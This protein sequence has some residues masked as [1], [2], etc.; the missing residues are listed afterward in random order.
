[1]DADSS[2]SRSRTAESTTGPPADFSTHLRIVGRV[3]VTEYQRK[4]QLFP[5]KLASSF[6]ICDKK[7][8]LGID[9]RRFAWR[10]FSLARR[11]G[12]SRFHSAPTTEAVLSCDHFLCIAQFEV[13]QKNLR[14]GHIRKTRHK[15]P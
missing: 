2:P 11:G 13:R 7:L 12:Q 3:A 5:E 15:P 14:I 9:N 8:R 10:R 4:A 6:D 1:M